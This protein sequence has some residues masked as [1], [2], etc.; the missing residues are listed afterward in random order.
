MVTK[1]Y[2]LKL[3]LFLGVQQHSSHHPCPYCT[4]ARYDKKGRKSVKGDWGDGA[5]WTPESIRQDNALWLRKGRRATKKR[6][7]IRGGGGVKK[8][9]AQFN[10][11]Q[12][13]PI[14]LQARQDTMVV[15]L[16]CPPDPLHCVLLGPVNNVFKALHK[17]DRQRMERHYREVGLPDRDQLYGG[18]FLGIHL[19]DLLS[20]E[21]LDK[22]SDIKDFEI[23]KR[24]LLSLDRVHILATS[25]KLPPKPVYHN[26][27]EEYRQA[28][29]EAVSVGVATSTPKCH[30]IGAHFQVTSP[31]FIFNF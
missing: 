18:N 30:I 17:I 5:V 20:D 3:S 29:K 27:M 13:V 19:K 28:H 2:H 11:C 21:A 7:G 26:I 14:K 16:V 15:L 10:S 25:K 31:F 1:C 12:D 6:E 22:L 8:K 23:I 24:Y 9:L 4:A